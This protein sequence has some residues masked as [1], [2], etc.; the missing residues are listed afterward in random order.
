MREALA[1]ARWW[2]VQAR[3]FNRQRDHVHSC[4]F[5]RSTP[6]LAQLEGMKLTTKPTCVLTDAE[7]DERDGTQPP[8]RGRTKAAS[9]AKASPGTLSATGASAGPRP[10]MASSTSQSASTAAPGA[11]PASA[12]PSDVHEADS[13]SSSDSDSSSSSSGS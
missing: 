9:K 4:E 6:S 12:A 8:P 7:L 2:A 11:L 3:A 5:K 13:T 10:S 1:Q